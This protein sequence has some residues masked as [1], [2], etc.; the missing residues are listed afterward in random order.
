MVV[1]YG[2]DN[3]LNMVKYNKG[4][5]VFEV[6]FVLVDVSLIVFVCVGFFVFL[7]FIVNFGGFGGDVIDGFSYFFDL[8]L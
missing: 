2:I 8:I 4:V 3:V 7:G 5:V 1:V 6:V